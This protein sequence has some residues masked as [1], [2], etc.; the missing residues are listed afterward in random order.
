MLRPSANGKNHLPHDT[1]FVFHDLRGKRWPRT[2]RLLVFGVLLLFVLAVLFTQSILL[3]PQLPLSS[4]RTLK[5]NISKLQK[6]AAKTQAPRTWARYERQS[7]AGQRQQ[8]ILQQQLHP[9]PVRPAGA[10]RLG[11]YASWDP[12][13]VDALLAHAD[14]LT[15]I[16]P[17]WFT[18]T[19]ADGTLTAEND[20]QLL[21]ILNGNKNLVMMPQLT[22][23]R[24]DA[25]QPEPV[26]NLVHGP[27][28]VQDKFIADLRKRLLDLKAGGVLIDWELI[29]P[30]YQPE[31]T[32]FLQRLAVGLHDAGLQLWLQVQMGDE[33][34]AY[35]LETLADDVDFFVA[36]L[37]DQ[38]SDGDPPGPIAGQDW[39]NGWLNTLASYRNP[40]QWIIALG[41][42]GYDWAEGSKRADQI[43]FADAMSRAAYAGED[44]GESA[45]PSYNPTFAYTLAGVNHSVWFLDAITFLNQARSAR[46]RGFSGLAITRLGTGDPHTWDA[47]E[48]INSPEL[49]AEDLAPLQELKPGKQI[50]NIGQGE[51]VTV[52]NSPEEGS[53]RLSVESDGRVS[54]VYEKF[55]QY[56]S[57]YHQGAAGEHLVALTFDD[58][59]DPTWTSPILDILKEKGVSATFFMCGKQVEANPELAQ[60]IVR[61]GHELGNH[62]YYHTNLALT[63]DWQTRTEL[64]ATQRL[65]E[66]VTSRS[67]TLFR[68]PYN[69]DERPNEL[70]ELHP[71]VIAQELHYL[72][73]LEAIDPEDWMQPGTDVILQRVKQLRHNGSIILLHD[74]GGDRH[75]TVEALP[76]IIDYL[77]AR[78]DTI[79]PVSRLL[80]LTRDDVNPIVQPG[81]Q[82]LA[83]WISNIGFRSAHVVFSF[84]WA[85]LVVS[86]ALIVLRTL[87]VIA[88]AMRQKRVTASV[89]LPR[90]S[91]PLSVVIAAYNEEKVISATLHAVLD[92][93]HAG[94]VEVLVV[95][96][97]S[98]DRTAEVVAEIAAADS[99]VRLLRQANG[100]KSAAL[101]AGVAAASHELLVFLDADTLFQRTTLREL[102]APFV[103]P[104]VGAVSGHARVGNLRSF[105]GRCQA[106]EYICGF[107]LD[108]R[109]YDSWNCI[110]VAPGAISALRRSALRQVGGFRTDTLAEDTDLTLGLHRRGWRVVYASGAIAYTEAPETIGTLAKQRFRWCFGTMQCLWKHRDLLFNPRFP[111]LGFFSLPSIWF[112]QIGL[113]AITPL[114]DL[115]LLAGL[116]SGNGRVILPYVLVFLLLD[117]V[118]AVLACILENEPLRRSWIMVPMRLIYRP[119]L[120]WVVWRSIRAA[121]RGGLVG[122]GKLERT[123]SASVPPARNLRPAASPPA[124]VPEFLPK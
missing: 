19:S 18:L 82:P 55:P 116:F 46:A 75:Q 51:I 20:T 66:D 97:G 7:A 106:L 117:Q 79:V 15:H 29:D 12:N 56:P 59:P 119:L 100:G 57:L 69:A 78:G 124:P 101:T 14:K 24:G 37:H 52:D 45:A 68:P 50:T 110:T 34:Q 76:R 5:P 17:E 61:E 95:D 9:R 44:A 40:E 21:A 32:A 77:R 3:A 114:V 2:R 28:P 31:L 84:L 48:L 86:T 94:G 43:S 88:L 22:N 47:L 54:A 16:C 33:L 64:N 121:A 83:R 96:D 103:N 111:G 104:R 113:V 98:K 41:N 23:L 4:L 63:A 105:I 107:N 102:V 123:A 65:I 42:Y 80:G 92:T 87:V 8:E 99:R 62:T 120:S 10:I 36:L 81:S 91:A 90:P 108:R 67:T 49:K 38:T 72:T 74:A 70:A 30:A 85:F 6:A 1:K 25:R 26:E 115:I 58:G 73:V 27:L 13:S 39:F 122:W 60:R 118:L 89:H 35:D 93:D 109:A 112:F 71:L 11:Y 53:R